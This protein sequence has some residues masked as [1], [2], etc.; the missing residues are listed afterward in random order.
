MRLQLIGFAFAF[1]GMVLMSCNFIT[2]K[3]AMQGFNPKTFA[4]LWYI[5][6]TI[7]SL[8][9]II[10]MGQGRQLKVRGAGLRLMLWLGLALT[11]VALLGW[12][13][14][15]KMDPTFNSFLSRLTP[16]MIILLGVILLKERVRRLEWVAER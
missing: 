11:F 2:A 8:V 3:I 5:A 9:L 6:A 7:Y 1:G 16:M 14:L 13:A 15:S 12:L 4:A 10:S